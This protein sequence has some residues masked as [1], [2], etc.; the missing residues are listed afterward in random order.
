LLLL[1]ACEQRTPESSPHNAPRPHL[2]AATASDSSK[3]PADDWLAFR[4]PER[5]LAFSYPRG[6]TIEQ[7]ESLQLISPAGS[8]LT[9]SPFV[10]AVDAG[11]TLKVTEQALDNPKMAGRSWILSR[12]KVIVMVTYFADP[13]VVEAEKKHVERIIRTATLSL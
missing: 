2:A 10:S 4:S 13:A 9:W 6:W 11:E 12:R 8:A 3:A 5:G 7:S 1:V